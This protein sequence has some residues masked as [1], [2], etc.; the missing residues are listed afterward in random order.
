[1]GILVRT[2]QWLYFRYRPAHSLI[3]QGLQRSVW[4]VPGSLLRLLSDDDGR[5][6]ASGLRQHGNLNNIIHMSIRIL[7]AYPFF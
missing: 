5:A 1:M 3:L 2:G 7:R 6:R 4:A